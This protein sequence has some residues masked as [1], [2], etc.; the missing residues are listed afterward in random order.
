MYKK[1]A[2]ATT[3]T[4]LGLLGACNDENHGDK[5]AAH[6]DNKAAHTSHWSYEG[7]TGPAHWNH[8]SPDYALCA[9][10]KKQSP[11]NITN[12]EKADLPAL[13]FNYKPIPLAIQNN[14]HSIK[15]PADTAGTLTIGKDTYKLLQFHTH[16]PSEMTIDGKP[17]DMVIHMVHQNTKG[18]L[19]VVAIHFK[20]GDTANPVIEQLW[21][22]MPKTAGKVQSH[23][24]VQIDVNQLLPTDQNYYAF[25]GSLTT[26]PCSEGVRWMVLKQKVSISAEQLAQHKALYPNNV[27]PVQALN[28]RKILSSN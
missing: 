26:P 16:S 27:R 28:G 1:L 13:E 11:I 25:E 18:E 2:I 6:N 19:A 10:G 23:D 15:M 24:K 8:V 7:N 9:T 21:K 17:A 3:I 12:S 22:V 20:V 5:A 14:G 4:A